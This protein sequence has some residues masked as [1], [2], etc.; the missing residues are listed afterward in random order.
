MINEDIRL[1]EDQISACR[2]CQLGENRNRAVPGSGP[3]P[4]RMMLVGEAPGREEDQSGQ[5]FVGR[6]GRLLDV[7]LQQ[8][9]LK[10][11]EI[12]ITSV[13]KCRPPNNRKPMKKEM[14]SCLPYL[15]AQMEIVRPKIVCLLGN[16]AAA[17]VLGRQGI[18]SL[19]GQ[20]WQER[21]AVTYH[22][23]AV[24]RNRNLMAEFVSD[25]ERL[26]SL[27]DQ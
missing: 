12:F 25:L 16:T 17:A 7:A 21:F 11:S 23:A 27:Q 14:A 1:L 5:P 20:L 8:A 4:A 24:L 22:P 13:I 15:Q 10:R 9:G 3:A 2:L 6:G 26:N 18:Q 19:R